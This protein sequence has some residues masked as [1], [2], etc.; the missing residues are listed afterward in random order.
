M[1]AFVYRLYTPSLQVL[2]KMSA[3]RSI[4][5]VGASRGIGLE[6][7]K[8]LAA[9]KRYRVLATV[10]SLTSPSPALDELVASSEGR[11][12]KMELEMTSEVS[13]KVG[14]NQPRLAPRCTHWLG[15]ETHPSSDAAEPRGPNRLRETIIA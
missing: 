10:R 1:R 9:S 15:N 13:A 8:Q 11:I 5:I 7:V 4:C 12:S 6:L 2:V 14:G 3:S